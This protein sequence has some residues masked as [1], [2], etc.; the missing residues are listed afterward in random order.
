MPQRKQPTIPDAL[1]EQL[2]A[3]TDA[4][5]ALNYGELFN[6][7]NKELASG[8]GELPRKLPIG[9]SPHPTLENSATAVAIG[10]LLRFSALQ[11]LPLA[12]ARKI[13]R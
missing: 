4:K 10:R 6:A 3:G 8:M 5:A 1:L 9:S 11:F 13:M 7:P 12:E 2:L